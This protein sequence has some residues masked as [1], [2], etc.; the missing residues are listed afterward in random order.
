MTTYM[1]VLTS[2]FETLSKLHEVV[3]VGSVC[4]AGAQGW[5]RGSLARDGFTL[6]IMRG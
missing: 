6:S 5:G 2:N 3:D 1:G 4:G